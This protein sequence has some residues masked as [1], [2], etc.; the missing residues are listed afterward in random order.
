M[1]LVT[2]GSRRRPKP[3][4]QMLAEIIKQMG[5][6]RAVAKKLKCSQQSVSAWAL[7]TTL[8]RWGMQKKMLKLLGIPVPWVPLP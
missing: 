3:N 5:S 6:G 8:P 1:A 2:N 7:G 4:Q